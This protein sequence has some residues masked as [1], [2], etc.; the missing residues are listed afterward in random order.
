MKALGAVGALVDGN[1][2]DIPGIKQAGLPL[3]ATGRVPGHGPFN[4][5]EQNIEVVIASL[6]IAPGDIL[7]CDADGTTRVE[8]DMAADVAK[9]C[10]EVRMKESA[11]HQFFAAKDFTLETRFTLNLVFQRFYVG[12]VTPI[13]CWSPRYKANIV[14]TTCSRNILTYEPKIVF[15]S[16]IGFQIES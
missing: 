8:V 6:K 12:R 1:A 10:A 2:R 5:I 11:V 16:L 15:S 4:M 7:V 9:M 14:S 3:W 13:R